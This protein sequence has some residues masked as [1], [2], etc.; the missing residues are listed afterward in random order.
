MWRHTTW[1]WRCKLYVQTLRGN[2]IESWC[3]MTTTFEYKTLLPN[4]T[5]WESLA[6]SARGALR[7][8]KADFEIALEQQ[9][10]VE[11][12]REEL[13]T[14]IEFIQLMGMT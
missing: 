14:S 6:R 10:T 5:D 9:L 2:S 13:R 1:M 4:N 7:T 3:A 11:E 8:L 12:L